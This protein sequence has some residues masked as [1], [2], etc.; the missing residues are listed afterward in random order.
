MDIKPVVLEGTHVRLEPLAPEHAPDLLLAGH[1]EEVWA[2]LTVPRPQTLSEMTGL[3]ETAWTQP[4]RLPFAIIDRES[5]KAIGSTSY[6]DIQPANR[7][8]EIGWTWLSKDYWRSARNTECK[9]L[10]MQHAF[11]AQGALRVQLKT[12]SR[13]NRSQ[14]AIARIGGVRE[15]T[16]RKNVILYN[17]YVR[18][19]VYFSILATE[20]PEVKAR[21]EAILNK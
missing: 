5:G 7:G 15:G 18:D 1:A 20:W 16:L 21:L 3:I 2:Y 14:E 8:I 13:N 4:G 11:E 9:Y 10:L 6:L 12:D 17:G 19:S